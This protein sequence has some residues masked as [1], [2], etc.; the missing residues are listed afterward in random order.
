MLS[1]A[2]PILLSLASDH[3]V[4][5]VG[6]TPDAGV[7]SAPSEVQLVKTVV[8]GVKSGD[9]VTVAAAVLVIAVMVIR[10]FGKQLHEAIDDNNPVDKVFWF[11]L[12]TKPGGW[13]LN[14]LTSLTGAMGS[15]IVSGVAVNWELLKPVLLVSL[16]GAS[17]WELFKDVSDFIKK[18]KA[19]SAET[20]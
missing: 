2:L 18:P 8:V 1:L 5:L 14:F 12:E 7:E 15:A 10:K 3:P 4:E 20:K 6:T 11:F 17:L 9:W 13:L 16:T 19:D